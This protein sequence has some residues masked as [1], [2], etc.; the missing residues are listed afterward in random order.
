[1]NDIIAHANLM[2]DFHSRLGVIPEYEHILECGYRSLVTAGD[3]VVDVGAHTG[4]HTEILADLVGPAGRVFAFEPLPQARRAL[5]ARGLGPQ[6]RV[7]D[8]ALADFVGKSS[9]VHARGTPEESGLRR[10]VYNRPDLVKPTEIE[11]EV[12]RLDDFLPQLAG[13]AFVKIDAEGAEILC[14]R[15]AAATLEQL[16]PFVSVEYGHPS[17]T[18]YGNEPRTLF[19]TAGSVG[20]VVGDLFGATCSDLAEWEAVCDTAYWDWFL[21]PQ[22]RV[23]EWRNRLRNWHPRNDSQSSAQ[24]GMV[25][26]RAEAAS[27]RA[28]NA[29]MKASASWRVTRPLR[30]AKRVLLR[31]IGGSR[32]TV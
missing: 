19:D 8:Y 10:K 16:R 22:E 15:G 29:A 25:S 28:E 27:L 12:R 23:D 18:A 2:A 24:T 13:L 3:V 7:F 20:Y 17:Y 26:L 1:L 14:L 9:F 11:V 21:V 30:V 31:S 32:N 5:E 4:R 6:V